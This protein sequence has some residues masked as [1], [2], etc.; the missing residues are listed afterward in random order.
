M[1]IPLVIR[2]VFGVNLF[3]STRTVMSDGLANIHTASPGTIE[4][5]ESLAWFVTVFTTSF[6]THVYDL[7]TTLVPGIPAESGPEL[8]VLYMGDQSYSQPMFN[9]VTS[10]YV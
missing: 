6:A 9:F 8:L 2:L 4:T 5:F 1:Y 7:F 10:S 3:F